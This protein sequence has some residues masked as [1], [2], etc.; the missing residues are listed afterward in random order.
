MIE[1]SEEQTGKDLAEHLPLIWLSN[2]QR[3]GVSDGDEQAWQ[4]LL[5]CGCRE[6]QKLATTGATRH[7]CR[8]TE[9]VGLG[10]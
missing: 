10:S 9:A 5:G 2:A 4:L 3:A 8:R 1:T 7:G 6:D